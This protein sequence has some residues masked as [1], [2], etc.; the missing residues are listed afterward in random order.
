MTLHELKENFKRRRLRPEVAKGIAAFVAVSSLSIG[1][2]TYIEG[3]N[4]MEQAMVA[5][6]EANV[7]LNSY[8]QAVAKY[9]SE[10][11]KLSS[12]N[13]L[14]R[15]ENKEL[16]AETEKLRREVNRGYAAIEGFE[17][18]VTAYTLSES[19]CSKGESHPDYGLT[20]NGTNLA[21]HTLESA[22]AI[23][24]DP[25]VIPM[26]SKVQISFHD[27]AMKQYDGIYTACDTGGA[28]KGNI[29]DLFAGDGADEL[30][31]HIGRRKA[32]VKIL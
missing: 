20:A 2:G 29:I 31:R 21:G 6:R 14:L 11:D 4:K 7:M 17:V 15:D 28:I 12:A 18:E 16:R 8:E 30:A 13:Q 25:R 5:E 3:T 22:R 24:V 19:D 32:T 1:I 23:A 26:G 10:N 9:Q 27:A